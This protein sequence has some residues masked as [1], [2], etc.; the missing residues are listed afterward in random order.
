[1]TP[2]GWWAGEIGAATEFAA[3][4]TRARQNGGRG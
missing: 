4:I 1:M 3:L 2:W